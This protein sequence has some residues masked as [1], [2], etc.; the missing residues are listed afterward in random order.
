M[1]SHTRSAQF[2][3]FTTA[4]RAWYSSSSQFQCAMLLKLGTHYQQ[5][6]DRSD[7]FCFQAFFALSNIKTYSLA[8]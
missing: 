3:C 1:I 8:L 4:L 7:V 2:F 5:K 6:L